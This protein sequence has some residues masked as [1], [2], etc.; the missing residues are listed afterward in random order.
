MAQ[1][2]GPK[3]IDEVLKSKITLSFPEFDLN[4]A[5]QE[6]QDTVLTDF[7]NLPFKF[8]ILIVGGDLEEEGITRNQKVVDFNMQDATVADVLTA[9]VR[10]ANPVTTV[11]DPSEKDQKLLWVVA[12]DPGDSSNKIVLIT[13]R[14]V[15]EQ[16][17]TIPEIFRPK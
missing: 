1:P 6:A 4:L 9:M 5:M 13:T 7:K 15:A 2:S 16:K 14:K 3:T 11:T 8:K 17:Y 12:P 10:K